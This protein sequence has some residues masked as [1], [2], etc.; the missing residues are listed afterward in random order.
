[1]KKIYNLLFILISFSFA[2]IFFEFLYFIAIKTNIGKR[3]Y[4]SD[5]LIGWKPIEN[6]IQKDQ[7]RKTS[8]GKP[9]TVDYS[10]NELGFRHG[11]LSSKNSGDKKRIF[12][13]GDSTTGSPYTSD[14]K[15]WFSYLEKEMPYEVFVSISGKSF[16]NCDLFSNT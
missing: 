16:L 9:Y 3:V 11:D 15:A 14:D 5:S 6:K 13:V 12:V 2:F 4:T 7:P 1:M 10:T 8:K